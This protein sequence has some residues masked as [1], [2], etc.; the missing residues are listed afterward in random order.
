V[1]QR[2]RDDHA[3]GGNGTVGAAVDDLNPI[4]LDEAGSLFLTRPRPADHLWDAETIRRRAADI[5]SSLLNGALSIEIAGRYR[6]ENVEEAHAA[7]EE[8]RS[9]GQPLL[10]LT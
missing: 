1:S 8:R 10:D 9:V 5:F 3:L 6:L 2:D 4:E 7:L